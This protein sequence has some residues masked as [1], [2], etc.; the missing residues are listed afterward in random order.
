[1]LNAPLLMWTEA[2]VA[3]PKTSGQSVSIETEIRTD[4]QLSKTLVIQDFRKFL[5]YPT[6]VV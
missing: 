6:I 5:W 2:G 1:M 3:I 4:R